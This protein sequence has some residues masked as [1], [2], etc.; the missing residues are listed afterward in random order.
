L[1]GVPEITPAVVAVIV[2]GAPEMLYDI[3]SEASTSVHVPDAS[4]LYA[5]SSA[6]LTSEIALATVGASLVLA[7]VTVNVSVAD[8]VPSLAVMTTL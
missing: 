4:R 2:L 8:A 7:T 3:V 6:V 1:T 5:A